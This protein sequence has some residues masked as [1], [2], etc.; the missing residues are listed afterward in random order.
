M[1]TT[2]R[3]N[4]DIYIY[5]VLKQVHPDTGMTADAKHMMNSALNYFADQIAREANYLADHYTKSSKKGGNPAKKK[6]KGRNT[7]SAREI[8]TSVRLVLPGELAKHAVS[9]GTKAVTK[10]TSS[11]P[12]GLGRYGGRKTVMRRNPKVKRAGLQFPPPLLRRVIKDF[13][14]K[15]ISDSAPVYFAAVIEYLCAEILELAGNSARSHY[16]ARINARDLQLAIRN[17]EELNSM[18]QNIFI[19]GGGVLP[20]I[21][22]VL[23]PKRK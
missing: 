17:D 15:R 5:K 23:L 2:P 3:V 14:S 16:R 6:G 18:F 11:S 19:P 8:Q 22:A 13:T 9:E 20:N 10:Y 7:I 21:H 4:F 12:G 1:S